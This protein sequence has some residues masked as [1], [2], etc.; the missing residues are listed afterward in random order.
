MY[1]ILKNNYFFEKTTKNIWWFHF[2]VVSLQCQAKT[3]DTMTRKERKEYILKLDKVVR[4]WRK[5]SNLFC[6]GCCFSAGQI[7]KLL[8]NKGIRYQVICWSCGYSYVRSLKKIILDG[9]CGHIGIAVDLD[10][11][12]FIIGGGFHHISVNVI[13]VYRLKSEKLIKYDKLGAYYDL[14]N[15]DYNRNLNGRFV[16]ILNKIM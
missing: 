16:N 8:E 12:K 7:A 1:N 15:W 14:W 6:G 13:Y 10:G 11:E 9:D 5:N 3:K 2:F 4:R